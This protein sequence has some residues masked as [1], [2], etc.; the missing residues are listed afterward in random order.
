MEERIGIATGDVGSGSTLLLVDKVPLAN[1]EER[2]SDPIRTV[3][4]SKIG[5]DISADQDCTVK[6][7]RL[8]D[9]ETPFSVSGIGSVTGGTPAFFLYS[10]LMCQAV[11]VVVE[12]TGGSDMTTFE[13]YVR[14]GA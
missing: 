9:G 2:E 8:P 6:L 5:I 13:M 12:N 10:S 14:G 11:Q 7:V 1:G 4:V 3:Y